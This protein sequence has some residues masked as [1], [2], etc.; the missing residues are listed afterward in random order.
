MAANFPV[1]FSQAEGFGWVWSEG[2]LPRGDSRMQ[3]DWEHP[4]LASAV[5]RRGV[6]IRVS[7]E[8]WCLCM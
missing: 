6:S 7:K 3:S 8:T 1:P 2:T 5:E 4:S